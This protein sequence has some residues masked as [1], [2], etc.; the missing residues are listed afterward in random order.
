MAQVQ[1][2]SGTRKPKAYLV[3]LRCN[4]RVLKMGYDRWVKGG[5][6]L[7]MILYLFSLIALFTCMRQI[8]IYLLHAFFFI[9][10]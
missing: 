2:R 8:E 4:V 7:K 10:G 9:E 3:I 5:E 1:K 6:P